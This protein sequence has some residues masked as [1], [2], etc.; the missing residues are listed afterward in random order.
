METLVKW[1][2]QAT[3]DTFPPE[4]AEAAITELKQDAVSSKDVT[5]WH[6]LCKTFLKAPDLKTASPR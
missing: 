1:K 6:H 5:A 4:L 3:P 2:A